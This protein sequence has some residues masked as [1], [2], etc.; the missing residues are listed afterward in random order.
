V[1]AFG[2]PMR[3]STYSVLR[4]GKTD[5]DI[6]RFN[7][8]HRPAARRQG[9]ALPTEASRAASWGSLLVSGAQ[10]DLPTHSTCGCPREFEDERGRPSPDI[11]PMFYPVVAISECVG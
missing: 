9:T 8:G 11:E 2:R 6:S 10:I 3:K 7:F 5:R 4:A 1:S